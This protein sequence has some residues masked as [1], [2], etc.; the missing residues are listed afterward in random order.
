MKLRRR[1]DGGLELVEAWRA[2]RVDWRGMG[3]RLGRNMRIGSCRRVIVAFRELRV[4]WE[5][6]LT[7]LAV[8]VVG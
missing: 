7:A 8:A 5:E 3:R 2:V 6:Q 1:F 4:L